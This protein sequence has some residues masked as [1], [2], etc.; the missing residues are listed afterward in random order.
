MQQYMA[1]V[2]WISRVLHTAGTHPVIACALEKKRAEVS[3]KVRLQR[4]NPPCA[5]AA[6]CKALQSSQGVAG[7]AVKQTPSWPRSWANCSLL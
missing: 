5:S 4:G 1:G 3:A 7:S 6:C 2:I